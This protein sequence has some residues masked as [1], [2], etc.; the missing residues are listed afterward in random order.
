M[1]ARIW[2]FVPTYN[3]AGN[4]ESL[5]RQAV[6]HLE[7]AVPG[8]YRLLV[9]D[10]NSPDGT[11][12]LAE[13][14]AAELVTIEVL[15][16]PRKEGLG[17]AYQAGFGHALAHGAELVLVM[18]ADFS[19]DPAYLP[20]L[21]AAAADAD[22]VIASRYCPGARILDWS[23]RRRLLSAAGALYARGIL[24]RQVRD[25]TGGFKCVRREVLEEIDLPGLRSQGYVFNIEL[26]YRALLSGFRVAEIPFDF[27]DR[28]EGESK[29]SLS[30]ALEALRLV[31][32]LR[33]GGRTW[34]R[35]A[36]AAGQSVASPRR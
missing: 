14:L 10:D 4:L 27:R 28:R 11:G 8:E 29:I 35:S 1:D 19:H 30:V 5:L 23:P 32:K 36:S 18:D 7:L 21:I 16:R 15:H 24:G 26:T 33:G 6:A 12:A 9:V 20:E 25:W 31:P 13:R 2:V 22:V 34:V 3:E 17:R